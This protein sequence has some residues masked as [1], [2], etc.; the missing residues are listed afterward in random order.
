MP[1]SQFKRKLVI[2]ERERMKRPDTDTAGGGETVK[3]GSSVLVVTG[4]GQ[5]LPKIR[6]SDVRDHA[7]PP[8]R[9]SARPT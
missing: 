5:H 9:E 1:K 6:R 7:E 3:Y 8:V 2:S 4:R